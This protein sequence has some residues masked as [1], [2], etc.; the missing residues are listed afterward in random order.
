MTREE[1]L[2]K[3]K[4]DRNLQ[5]ANLQRANLQRADLQRADLQ[6][7]NLQRADLQRADLQRADLW[8]ANLQE[9]NLRGA[10]LQGANLQ[11]ADLQGANLQRADL[12]GANLQGAKNIPIQY[13]SPLHILKW[14]S[15][16][17]KAFKY[18]KNMK[19]PYKKYPY[20]IGK[21]YTCNDFCDDER[22]LCGAGINVATL[23][24]CLVD[25]NMN[26]DLDYIIVEFDVSDIIAIPYNS[27][28]KFRVKKCTI[29]R[30]LTKNELELFTK[31]LY[32]EE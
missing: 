11:R 10:N 18:L 20:E 5:G 13:Q 3:Y 26:L 27:D 22:M 6:G 4:I 16:K 14:Q 9:A 1:I 32:Q 17:L 25:A 12:W 2:E 29:I 19:S 28:G 31:S 8:G 24:W 7:A 15:G 23:E 30:K 21:E